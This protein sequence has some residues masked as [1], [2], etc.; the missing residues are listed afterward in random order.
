[1]N[2][3]WKKAFVPCAGAVFVAGCVTISALQYAR[4]HQQ[5]SVG[6]SF[7]AFPEV[8]S[9]S[10]QGQSRL[11]SFKM[12]GVAVRQ[13]VVMTVFPGTPGARAGIRPDDQ[14]LT[15]NDIPVGELGKLLELEEN[16][17]R[18]D[19]VSYRMRRGQDE[20]TVVLE[21]ESPWVEPGRLIRA[22]ADILVGL[23]YLV[24][25]WLVFWKKREDRRALIFYWISMIIAVGFFNAPVFSGT[26]SRLGEPIN[27]VELRNL[28]PRAPNFPAFLLIP[29]LLH[30]ALVFPK[31]HRFVQ[32]YPALTR[33]V[34]WLPFFLAFVFV[35][36]APLMTAAMKLRAHNVVPLTAVVLVTAWLVAVRTVYRRTEPRP[37][38]IPWCIQH[39]FATLLSF[40]LAWWAILT[41]AGLLL[42][43]C[44]IRR[45]G[46]VFPSAA[47][48]IVALLLAGIAY[49]VATCWTFYSSF[50][51][52]GLEERRQIKWPLWGLTVTLASQ[53]L[54]S[55]VTFVVL[56]VFGSRWLTGD[57]TVTV[58]SILGA[59]LAALIP[60][61]FAVAILKYRLMEI[62]LIIKRTVVYSV[63][64]GIIVCL[65]LGMVGGLGGLVVRFTGMKNQSVAVLATVVV[66][67]VFLPIRTRVQGMLERSFFR[68]RHD[69]PELLKRLREQMSEAVHLR[70]L[71]TLSV[72][73]AQQAV[74]SRTAV[75]FLKDDTGFLRCAAKVGL[76]DEVLEGLGLAGKSA[77]A[78]DMNGPYEPDKRSWPEPESQV[79][80]RV[81]S[82]L[83]VPVCF[84]G[85]LLGMISL[86]PKLSSEDYDA[87]DRE[88]LTTLA[89]QAG[90]S[91]E[92]QRLGE[93]ERDLERAREIQE[94]LL[95]K[96]IPHLAGYSI[97]AA[98]QPARSVSGDYYDVFLVG[99]RKLVLCIADVSGKGLPAALL[100][101]NLQAAVR[102]IATAAMEPK[103]LC[104]R[105]NR[106]VHSNVV[107]GRFITFFYCLLDADTRSLTYTNAGHNPPLVM[108]KDGAVERLEKGGLVLGIFPD[109]NFA[110]GEVHLAP[111]DRLLLF[112]DGV[113]EA[114]DPDQQEFGE[115]RLADALRTAPRDSA[116]A[117]QQHVMAQVTEFCGN[118]FHDDASVLALVV[119]AA[120]GAVRSE[121]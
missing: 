98:W 43:L 60:L 16:V 84:K 1:M 71:V 3:W 37:G 54:L 11:P 52:S 30:L 12:M 18:G 6:L 97:A 57:T 24:V 13:G 70:Q 8:E 65:Y 120:A 41:V 109:A 85:D 26:A 34:Y 10:P 91:I 90:V 102:A 2:A 80:R 50:R 21:L 5:G 114:E 112:T 33:W 86:G 44:G 9:K 87:D 108:R 49:P 25:G 115:A 72:E 14:V 96:Q 74:Q 73:S 78:T 66:A 58:R 76:P 20:Y 103:E 110:Q 81:A 42:P 46:P 82:A 38:W 4:M 67:A 118:R 27:Q 55:V 56:L 106:V 36:M 23:L 47:F 99:D 105:V 61:S 113:S 117:L 62:D 59:A 121:P 35:P 104:Q 19:A 93:Q 15:V 88:F 45:F 28:L 22:A 32:K 51:E 75:F 101:S 63:L 7:L 92:H 77:L 94:A 40:A 119:E 107:T 31:E 79:L 64:T 68:K 116:E 95:P 83:L 29:L 39:P 111:G 17:R 48:A 100:M 89:Y 69:Y 53:T